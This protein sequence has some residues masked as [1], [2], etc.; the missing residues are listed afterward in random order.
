MR[1]VL[2][3]GRRIHVGCLVVLE[4]NSFYSVADTCENLVGYCFESI[5]EYGDGKIVAEDFYS[6][7]LFAWNARDV[8]HAG[9]HT[10]I[11]DVV[12]S[13][14]IYETIAVAIAEMSVQSV[15]ISYRDGGNDTVAVERCSAA[16]AYCLSCCYAM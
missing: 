6:V 13:L 9:I 14:P 16:V 15:G 5:R 2:R 12:C 1:G 11:A 10:Y 7:A 8:Y 3:P 4:I